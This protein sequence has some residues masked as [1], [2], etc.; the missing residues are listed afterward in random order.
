M[1][2]R[3]RLSYRVPL[4]RSAIDGVVVEDTIESGPKGDK[5][6]HQAFG[7]L[8]VQR[9][10]QLDGLRQGASSTLECHFTQTRQI[11]R[12]DCAISSVSLGMVERLIC[13]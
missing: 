11:R 7:G 6:A 2:G 12:I 13:T 1:A 5:M 3:R 10:A 9:S 4:P 8:P